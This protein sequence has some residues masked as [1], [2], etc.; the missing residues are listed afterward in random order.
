MK[1]PKRYKKTRLSIDAYFAGYNAGMRWA[2][3]TFRIK[4]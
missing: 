4:K 2:T 1:I 3:K